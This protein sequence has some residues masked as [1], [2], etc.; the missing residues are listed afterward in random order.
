MRLLY[1]VQGFK[2]SN[3]KRIKAHSSKKEE[4]EAN[5][6]RRSAEGDIKVRTVSL[7]FVGC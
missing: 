2:L 4:E 7:M 1:F 5:Q 3:H 6:Q